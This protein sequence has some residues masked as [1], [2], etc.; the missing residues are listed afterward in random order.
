MHL[1]VYSEQSD[2]NFFFKVSPIQKYGVPE[3]LLV[4]QMTWQ[5]QT[6][7]K[8][9]MLLLPSRIVSETLC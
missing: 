9:L 7:L 3:A 6:G 8:I 4:K 2:C 5:D 1:Y